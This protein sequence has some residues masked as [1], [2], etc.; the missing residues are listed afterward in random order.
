[1]IAS[2]RE[3]HRKQ[4]AFHFHSNSGRLPHR[5]S[6][7]FIPDRSGVVE[8]AQHAIAVAYRS[9]SHAIAA[10]WIEVVLV[11]AAQCRAGTEDEAVEQRRLSGNRTT[12]KGKL[13]ALMAAFPVI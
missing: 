4:N 2:D 11:P 9:I 7:A 10:E 5:G 3:G 12:K 1:M 13:C 6:R 8:R